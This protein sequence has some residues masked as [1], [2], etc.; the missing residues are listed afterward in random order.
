[1]MTHLL[2]SIL[3]AAFVVLPA[4]TDTQTYDPVVA[5]TVTTPDG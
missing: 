4:I 2:L 5:M 1:M 3:A